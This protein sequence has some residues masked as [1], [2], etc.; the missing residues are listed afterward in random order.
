[1]LHS[2]SN[3][4]PP[5]LPDDDDDDVPPDEGVPPSLLEEEEITEELVQNVVTGYLNTEELSDKNKKVIEAIQRKEG[6]RALKG[7]CDLQQNMSQ[8]TSNG[9]TMHI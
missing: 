1:M 7:F 4:P 2:Y 9:A 8:W 6:I 5:P 3:T